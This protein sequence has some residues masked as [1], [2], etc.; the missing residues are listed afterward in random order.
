MWA[1]I[2]KYRTKSLVLS[3]LQQNGF[4]TE[5]ISAITELVHEM[6]GQVCWKFTWSSSPRVRAAS[7]SPSMHLQLL[8]PSRGPLGSPPRPPM[9]FAPSKGDPNDLRAGNDWAGD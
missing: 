3:V 5:D 9:T 1:G 7:V 4:E 6:E 2:A 8:V